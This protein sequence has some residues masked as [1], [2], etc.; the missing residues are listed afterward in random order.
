MKDIEQFLRD[1][2]PG[3]PDEGQ[4][5]IETSARLNAVEGIKKTVDGENRRWRLTLIIA[6]LAGLLLGCFVTAL[7]LFYP[8]KI[9]GS[10]IGKAINSLQEWKPVLFGFIAACAVALGLLS[11]NRKGEAF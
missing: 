6:L 9:D 7:V 11:L 1:N 10:A 2:A 5:M 4:F 3:T 8:V